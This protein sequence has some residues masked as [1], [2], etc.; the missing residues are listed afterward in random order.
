[1]PNWIVIS[2]VA[3]E[4]IQKGTNFMRLSE[5]EKWKVSGSY[6]KTTVF[7]NTI[8]TNRFTILKDLMP[9]AFA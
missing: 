4:L 5:K 3:Q 1:M 6:R 2:S 8:K 7:L 9:S